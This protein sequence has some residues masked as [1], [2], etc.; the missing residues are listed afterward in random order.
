MDKLNYT[1]K[2][3]PSINVDVS[4]F[5]N[6]PLQKK[7]SYVGGDR[8]TFRIPGN[9]ANSFLDSKYGLHLKGKVNLNSVTN[10]VSSQFYLA[11]DKPGVASC[12]NAINIKMGGVTIP[13]DNYNINQCNISDLESNPLYRGNQGLLLEGTT[14]FAEGTTLLFE[15]NGSGDQITPEKAIL[16]FS[17]PLH[18]VLSTDQPI[19][20]FG[21]SPIDIEIVFEEAAKIGAYQYDSVAGGDDQTI[22]NSLVSYTEIELHGNYLIFSDQAM[23][24]INAMHG[25]LY[26]LHSTNW[27]HSTDTLPSGTTQFTSPISAN[28]SSMKRILVSH[29]NSDLIMANNR[30]ITEGVSSDSLSL[31]HHIN[32]LKQWHFEIDGVSYPSN[33]VRNVNGTTTRGGGM[34]YELMNADDKFGIVSSGCSLGAPVGWSSAIQFSHAPFTLDQTADGSPF[35]GSIGYRVGSY[36]SGYNFEVMN[37]GKSRSMRDG[38]STIGSTFDYHGIYNS[39]AT[40]DVVVD[41]FVQADVKLVLDTRG[42]NVLTYIS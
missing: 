20:L 21:S 22:I 8:I 15:R 13:Y 34:F 19:P 4:R 38:M 36:L 11:L 41:Y 9:M 18:T 5:Q 29:R 39:S 2:K 37:H 23:N 24:E 10:A 28:V 7:T 33:P 6:E 30:T 40:N 42:S 25:G 14:S 27:Y 17:L 32:D 16:E 1:S 26:E 3:S 35:G 31:G 12:I